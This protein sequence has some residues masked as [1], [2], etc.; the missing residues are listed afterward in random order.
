MH[1]CTAAKNTRRLRH[2][3]GHQ[4]FTN[5]TRT[6][7]PTVNFVLFWRERLNFGRLYPFGKI[8]EENTANIPEQYGFAKHLFFSFFFPGNFFQ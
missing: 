2:L 8:G 5:A 1:C 4:I 7:T 6:F 3:T